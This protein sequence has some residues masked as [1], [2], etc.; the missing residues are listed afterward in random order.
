MAELET[1][2]RINKEE[3]DLLYTNQI[4]NQESQEQQNSGNIINDKTLDTTIDSR[5]KVTYKKRILLTKIIYLIIGIIIYFYYFEILTLFV[6]EIKEGDPSID[7]G[8]LDPINVFNVRFNTNKKINHCKSEKSSH[9]CY[10]NKDKKYK[11]GG[12]ICMINNVLIDPQKW[13]DLNLEY[14]GPIDHSGRQGLP[15]LSKGFFEMK[16]DVRNNNHYHYN[17]YNFY[18]DAWNYTE[19]ELEDVEE[20]APNKTIFLIS[21]NQDSPNLFHGLSQVINAFSIMYILKLDPKDIQILYLDSM[22]F[23]YDPSGIFYEKMISRGGE[24]LY[25][26]NINKKFKIKNGIHIPIN[27]DSPMINHYGVPRCPTMTK[28]YKLFNEGINKYLNITQFIDTFN[29]NNE[30][31][32]YPKSILENKDRKFKKKIT[33]QWRRVWPKGRKGQDRILGNGPRLTDLLAEKLPKDY[34]I[35]LVDTS[36][37]SIEEQ[38]DLMHKTDYFISPHGAGNLL[39]IYMP[40]TSIFQEIY[41]FDRYQNNRQAIELNG[42]R[43]FFT[44]IQIRKVKENGNNY[45]YFNEKKFIELTMKVMEKVDFFSQ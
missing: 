42:H 30:F 37:Y 1:C 9:V 15:L 19:N 2:N 33:F 6:G 44:Y 5:T 40:T 16:C 31:L 25:I 4:K 38:I 45:I 32:Y 8:K 27:W 3:N 12:A 34:L 7:Y 29:N 39:G 28:T 17:K 36:G 43:T 35:R 24:P 14:K 21:R 10:Y 22:T 20:L 23:K 26:K 13:F 11:N 18:F 41:N